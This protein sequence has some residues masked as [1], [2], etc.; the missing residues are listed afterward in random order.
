MR[1]LEGKSVVITGGASGIGAATARLFVEHGAFVVIGDVQDEA[2][3]HLASELG[4]SVRYQH[5]DVSRE[6]DVSAAVA[7]AKETWG[8]VDVMFNNAGVMGALGPIAATEMAAAKRTVD[9]D[10]LGVVHGMKHAAVVMREQGSGVILCTSS[11][12]GVM[13]GVGPHIY[14]AVKAGI[15]ALTN[16]VAAELRPLGIRVNSIIPGAV[17]SQMTASILTND[18]HNL[19]GA[20]AA[21]DQSRYMTRPIQPLDVAYAALFLASDE[22]EL[23]T[24]VALPVDAGMTGAGGPAPFAKGEYA[25]PSVLLEGGR[26]E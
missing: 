20:T 21:L 17:V 24:G 9:I 26:I 11:P 12:A 8:S 5:V 4:P 3:G 18:A 6:A 16:S 23:I 7:L 2:G 10:L 22:A 14:S 13:G 19:S 25:T 1:R 15:I